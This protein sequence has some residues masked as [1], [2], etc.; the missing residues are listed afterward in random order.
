MPPQVQIAITNTNCVGRKALFLSN[1]QGETH[2]RLVFR[3]PF[4]A[5]HLLLWR[6]FDCIKIVPNGVRVVGWLFANASDADE[7]CGNYLHTRMSGGYMKQQFR[8]ALQKQLNWQRIV[9]T[10]AERNTNDTISECQKRCWHVSWNIQAKSVM[11]AWRRRWRIRNHNYADTLR[12]VRSHRV[13]YVR[14]LWQTM[15]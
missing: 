4:C 3:H 13:P 14:W 11:S 5:S 9:A 1:R 2:W 15:C 7:K 6:F 10:H 8:L 12:D